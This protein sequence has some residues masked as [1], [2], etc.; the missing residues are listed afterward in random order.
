[1]GER[2]VLL[3]CRSFVYFCA[4]LLAGVL[5]ALASSLIVVFDDMGVW[6]NLYAWASQNGAV[7]LR[8]VGYIVGTIVGTLIGCFLAFFIADHMVWRDLG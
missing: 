6:A 5:I 3:T 2:L 8:I 7:V 1:M 4:F